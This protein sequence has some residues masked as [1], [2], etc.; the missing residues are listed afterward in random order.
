MSDEM[1]MNGRGVM[2]R[3]EELK[4]QLWV[5]IDR[6]ILG[7]TFAVCGPSLTL[8]F[9]LFLPW[10]LAAVAAIAVSSVMIYAGRR[11]GKPH[12]DALKA[13]RD[14]R[15]AMLAETRKRGKGWAMS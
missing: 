9:F 4:D 2:D 3:T 8:V 14:H 6:A 13:V 7:D 12:R 1:Y 10:L 5:Y 15:E 11:Y